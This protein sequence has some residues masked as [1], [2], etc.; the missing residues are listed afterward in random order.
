MKENTKITIVVPVYNV[1]QFLPK[2]IDSLKNQTMREIAIILVNDGSTDESGKICDEY[3]KMDSRIT[4]VHKTNGGL[5]DARNAGT[6][7][8]KSKYLLYIDSDDWMDLDACETAYEVI[9]REQADMVFWTWMKEFP[10]YSLPVEP[11]F[12][13][14]TVFEGESIRFLQRRVLGLTGPEISQPTKTDALATAW[15]KL[16]RFEIIKDNELSF[17]D[18]KEIGS[19]DSLW[20]FE[21]FFYLK[22]AVFLHRHFGHYRK[23]NPNSLTKN[24]KASLLPRYLKLFEKMDHEIKRK[25]LGAEFVE[26]WYNRICFSTINMVLSITSSNNS[27]SRAQKIA[28]IDKILN[29]P[30]FIEAYSRLK[31]KYLPKHWY[32][33]FTFAKLRSATGIMLLSVFMKKF[34]HA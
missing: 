10:T 9:E 29:N 20:N 21:L 5:S 27:S 8:V 34:R 2:C 16:Y 18:T 28:D 22:K 4:V 15:G 17:V 6:Q 3:A 31:M 30:L 26:A 23:D 13:R 12:K 14:D 1:A 33:F 25:Q 11:I 7:F 24:H 32:V 19:E